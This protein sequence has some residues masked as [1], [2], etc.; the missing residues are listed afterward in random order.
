MKGSP[1]APVDR[2]RRAGT[3]HESA[4]GVRGLDAS[5]AARWT[6]CM[7]EVLAAASTAFLAAETW[8]DGM[9]DAA[10]GLCRWL[11]ENPGRGRVLFVDVCFAEEAVR[12]ARDQVLTAYADLIHLAACECSGRPVARE[13]ADAIIGAIWQR[14]STAVNARAF[15]SLPALVPQ[16]MY[17][18]VLPYFG[19]EAAR[20]ELRRGPADIARHE[21]G[22]PEHRA[23]GSRH[24]RG[25]A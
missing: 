21:R 10:W 13:H 9:R 5:F 22:E 20:E 3:E 2:G 16:L 25:E 14:A 12:A 8:R 11:Q 23:L 17:V 24:E 6:D 4:P 1:P 15:E 18:A 19:A 7:N